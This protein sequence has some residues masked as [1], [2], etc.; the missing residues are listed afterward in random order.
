MKNQEISINEQ[1][2]GA[3]VERL[4]ESAKKTV[5]KH[6]NDTLVILNWKIGQ[7]IS[8]DILKLQRAAYG[9]KI[10]ENLS[11][12]LTTK[13]GP[14]YSSRNLHRMVQFFSLYGDLKIVSS[15]M[16]QLDWTHFVYLITIDDPLKREF[17]TEMCRIEG[18]RSRNLKEKIAGMYYER[19]GLAKKPN[20]VIQAELQKLK[21]TG[22]VTTDYV[23]Q[24]PIIFNHLMGRDFPT[25]KSLEQAILNDIENFLLSFGNG[26]AFLE[27]QKSIEIDGEFFYIDLLMYHRRLRCLVVVE[28]KLGRFKAQDKGQTELYLRWLEKNEMQPNENPPI[29]I[30]L[31]SEKSDETVELLQL[32]DSGI[33]ISQFLT[34]L[35]PKEIFAERLHVAIKK[36]KER[37]EILETLREENG[38]E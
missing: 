17:Y 33:H 1:Q 23:I 28:L 7:R 27:R 32:N 35:P 15:L 10:I 18:W 19:I 21:K 31:C 11:K 14:G 20:E 2:L 13:Y 6:A 16:T 36:A 25:E 37:Y 8:I 30:I 3:D 12:R 22:E 9:K 38:D 5:I 26:F 24:D 34:E 29:G 4:I